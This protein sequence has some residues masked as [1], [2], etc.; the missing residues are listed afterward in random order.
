MA[1]GVPLL[2]LP[3]STDQFAG[4]AAIERAEVGVALPPNTATVDELRDAMS[5]VLALS[6]PRP[7]GPQ[8]RDAA[9]AAVTASV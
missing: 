6:V 1:Y 9:Y 2:V 3:F 5:R 8:G 4:A 7:T